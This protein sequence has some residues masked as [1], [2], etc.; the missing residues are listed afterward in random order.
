MTKLVDLKSEY[1]INTAKQKAELAA[2]KK[3]LILLMTEAKID[4]QAV[5]ALNDKIVALKASIS[6]ARLNK[7]L[8]VMNILTPEQREKIRHRMLVRSL[9][10]RHVAYKFQKGGYR[11]KTV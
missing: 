4:K 11:G 2:D 8:A 5:T 6:D 9:G 10:H 3:K 7:M 1:N